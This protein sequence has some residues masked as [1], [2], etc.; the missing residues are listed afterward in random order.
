[1]SLKEKIYQE[2]GLESLES[3]RWFRKLWFFF[4]I[5]KNESPDY[6]LKIIPQIHHKLQEIQTK[7][8]FLKPSIIFTKIRLSQVLL[9]NGIILIKTLG[10]V[11]F[12]PSSAL[13]S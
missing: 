7:F 1:M 6:L 4:K 3:R 11:K 2:L 10:T 5:L 9:L 12:I 8:L 13:V